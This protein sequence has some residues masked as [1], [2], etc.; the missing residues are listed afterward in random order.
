MYPS[1][2]RASSLGVLLVSLAPEPGSP[3]SDPAGAVILLFLS[4]IFCY[5]GNIQLA[6]GASGSKKI[7]GKTLKIIMTTAVLNV[8]IP[9]SHWT[10]D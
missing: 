1:E 6:M 3:A 2:A 10:T 9:Y 4:P 8:K 5:V 7:I